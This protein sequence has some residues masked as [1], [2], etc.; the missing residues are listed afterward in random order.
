MP[1]SRPPGACVWARAR[2]PWLCNTKR[3]A[4]SARGAHVCPVCSCARRT[5][6]RLVRPCAPASP[7]LPLPSFGARNAA[8]AYGLV[9]SRLTPSLLPGCCSARKKGRAPAKGAAK[10]AT[11]GKR[12][13]APAKAAVAKKARVE[14]SR[15]SARAATAAPAYDD[16]EDDEDDDEEE[17]EEAGAAMEE[18]EEEAA[19]EEEAWDGAGV[20]PMDEDDEGDEGEVSRP[21]SE[22]PSALSLSPA[23]CRPVPPPLCPLA[24]LRALT[25]PLPSDG[26]CRRPPTLRIAGGRRR[27]R[28]GGR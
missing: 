18:D 6:R 24:I 16:E 19:E 21:S 4:R 3:S 1:E 27:R 22:P 15:R 20:E 7:H 23:L 11:G 25:P 8:D 17:D 5:K 14:G 28:G 10:G 12:G 13:R 26:R 9:P 2:A